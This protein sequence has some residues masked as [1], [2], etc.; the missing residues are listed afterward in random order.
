MIDTMKLREQKSKPNVLM[1]SCLLVA[2][3]LATSYSVITDRSNQQTHQAI[4]HQIMQTKPIEVEIK[5]SAQP[6]FITDQ[7]IFTDQNIWSYVGPTRPYEETYQPPELVAISVEHSKDSKMQIAKSVVRPLERL[8]KAAENDGLNLIVASAYRSIEDQTELY[9]DFVDRLGEEAAKKYVANPRHSEHH[10]GLAV[11]ID[12]YSTD[13][14]IDSN[15]CQLSL[16]SANWLAD[17]APKFGFILRYPEGKQPITGTAYEAW[18]FRYVG[19]SL[20]TKLSAAGLTFDEFI[21]QV[22]PGR[23]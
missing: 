13:C 2:T 6:I 18:H 1:Y 17:N 3:V 5:G 11:D 22:S 7:A 10:S 9:Q 8:F 15:V 4:R 20:S 19:T 23:Q 14:L 21:S 12:D 16:E